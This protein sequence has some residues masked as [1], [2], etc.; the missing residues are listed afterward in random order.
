MQA[1]AVSS[2]EN[3]QNEQIVELN[4]ELDAAARASSKMENEYN[5][6]LNEQAIEL[7]AK[8]ALLEA[9]TVELEQAR[10]I[11]RDCQATIDNLGAEMKE[12]RAVIGGLS[13]A[14]D[15]Q[16]RVKGATQ[17]L[18][19]ISEA[20]QITKVVH[21]E[22]IGE[23][24]EAEGVTPEVPGWLRGVTPE[25]L[26]LNPTSLD[27][28]NSAAAEVD[29]TD[30]ASES[31]AST[32]ICLCLPDVCLVSELGPK[33][34][35]AC[36]DGDLDSLARYLSEDPQGLLLEYRDT[37]NGNTPLIWAAAS[38]QPE[39]CRLLLESGASLESKGA[40]CGRVSVL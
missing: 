32:E 29:G 35:Q 40:A 8:E 30:S 11:A 13:Q 37:G 31:T 9:R 23:A 34:I 28:I 2:P 10:K 19:L 25:Q 1:N 33:T 38:N 27:A 14:L 3:D 17:D 5:A 36:Q 21:P 20:Q 26:G 18:S 24:A 6:C 16:D 39:V 22:V 12:A 4:R 7:K 15:S